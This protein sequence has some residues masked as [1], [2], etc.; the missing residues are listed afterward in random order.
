MKT[1]RHSEILRLIGEYEIDTQ[2]ELVKRLNDAGFAATQATVSRDVRQLG[3]IKSASKGGRSRYV[4]PK[5]NAS[6]GKYTRA[7]KEAVLSMQGA[8]NLVV[9]KTVSG[10]AMSA[11]AGLDEMNIPGIVGCIAGDDTIFVAV[12]SVVDVNRVIEEIRK[13]VE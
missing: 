4:A 11:A 5:E 8:G 2:E 1:S 13:T 3:L 10:M 9:I 7:L 12:K 6:S